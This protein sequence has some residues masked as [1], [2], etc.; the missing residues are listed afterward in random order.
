MAVEIQASSWGFNGVRRFNRQEGDFT[1]ADEYN[2]YLE[3]KEDIIFNLTERIDMEATT[4]R[5]AQYEQDNADTILAANL[6]Q[7]RHVSSIERFSRS[8]C[9]LLDRTAVKTGGELQGPALQVLRC[10]LTD[11]RQKLREL[12]RKQRVWGLRRGMGR[13]RPLPSKP[14]MPRSMQKDTA[15][16]YMLQ[17]R[18]QCWTPGAKLYCLHPTPSPVVVLAMQNVRY[19]S[20]YQSMS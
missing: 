11:S 2:D 13:R 17:L 7:A 6:R 3:Q 9:C 8:F 20:R 5:L 18:P 16:C 19:G 12:K 14:Q 4:I 10:C 1:C 15:A